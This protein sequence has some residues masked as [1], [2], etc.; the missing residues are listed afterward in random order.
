MS[1]CPRA[2]DP[3]DDADVV[4]VDLV[5]DARAPRQ[6]REIAR[7]ALGRWNLGALVD[8]V[9]LVVS[10][11]V[12]NGVRYGR[13]PLRL[14]LRR[15]QRMLRVDVGDGLPQEPRERAGTVIGDGESGRGLLI[16]AAV[17]DVMGVEQVPGDGKIVYAAFKT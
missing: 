14:V 13:P 3:A 4:S 9:V 12:T 11:L 5:S 6:A 7:E 8:P 15:S 2:A 17:A 16:V 1:T 10:E